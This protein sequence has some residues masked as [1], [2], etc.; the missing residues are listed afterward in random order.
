MFNWFE[1]RINPFPE[2]AIKNGVQQT[3]PK[4]FW[5]FVW[6]ATQG[7]RPFLLMM[8][9]FTALLG[10]FEAVLFAMMGKFVD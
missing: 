8:T 9:L 2:Q 10:A 1:N 4:E 7:L 5:T 3:P 6:A